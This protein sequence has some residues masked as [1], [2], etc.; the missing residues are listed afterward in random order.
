[1]N[2]DVTAILIK[3]IDLLHQRLDEVDRTQQ[4]ILAN[5]AHLATV[6]GLTYVACDQ[7][8][9]LPAETLNEPLFARFLAAYPIDGPAI[10]G[11]R[12][13]AAELQ[14]LSGVDPAHLAPAF[15]RLQQDSSLT[16]VQRI[17]NSQLER[18]MREKHGD[19]AQLAAKTRDAGASPS[20]TPE[21]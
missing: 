4:E 14:R 6:G 5:L 18:A 3:A 8:R 12:A 7:E 10:I 1:M 13:M 15:E 20:R 16:P 2:D 21:R 17:R 9:P 19:L 11:A